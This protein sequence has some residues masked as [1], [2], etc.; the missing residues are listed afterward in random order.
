MV[1]EGHKKTGGV[2]VREQAFAF[3]I[4]FLCAMIPD[5]SLCQ[6][7]SEDEQ[8][9]NASAA[10]KYLSRYTSYGVDLSEDQPAVVG[11]GYVF[12][13]SGVNAGA[14]VVSAVGSHSGYQQSSLHLGYVRNIGKVL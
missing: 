11:E 9:W 8:N 14:A 1:R 12:H 3:V 5:V 4:L 10:L 13:S 7:E 6:E 2:T